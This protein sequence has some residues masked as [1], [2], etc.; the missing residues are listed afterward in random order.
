[1]PVT[2]VNDGTSG[3]SLRGN[4]FVAARA[5][6]PRATRQLRARRPHRWAPTS[7]PFH[8]LAIGG[9]ESS[10][11][12]A[13]PTSSRD[14]DEAHGVLRLASRRAR[15]QASS[16][17][18]RT[19]ATTC[20][21]SRRPSTA[22]RTAR[23]RSSAPR[24]ASA[25]PSATSR[26]PGPEI[27]GEAN[28]GWTSG[29]FFKAEWSHRPCEALLGAHTTIGD[30]W[31][32]GVGVGPGTSRATWA[33]RSSAS[34]PRS[35]GSRRLS[36]SPASPGPPRCYA[37][38]GGPLPRSPIAT[39]TASPTRQDACLDTPG[40]QHRLPPRPTAA[41]P[42]CDGDAVPAARKTLAPTRP[43]SRTNDP[44]T[45]GCPSDVAHGVDGVS[46]RRGRAVP[47]HARRQ[48]ERPAR[49]P[50]A[51]PIA[52][53]TASRTTRTPAPTRPARRPTIRRPTVVRRR[54][55]S[56]GRSRSASR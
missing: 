39:A 8:A 20:A 26:R 10:S 41:R 24:R 35:S 49:P 38:R 15:R 4:A 43:A 46:R 28:T 13:R 7:S 22:T 54:R 45:N 33:R 2:V 12:P 25:W 53:A 37:A 47:R 50:A 29:A 32:V 21:A 3:T 23:P 17:G 42:T 30:D 5:R 31:R 34:S 27:Y 1:M 55:S 36:S 51:R 14:D 40:V 19:S 18:R 44:K 52:T 48:D 9:A 16:S 56:T 6:P 11:R